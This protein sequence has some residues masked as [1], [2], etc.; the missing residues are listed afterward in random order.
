M[1]AL[2][3]AAAKE[4][5]ENAERSHHLNPESVVDKLLHCLDADLG[6]VSLQCWIDSGGE[7]EQCRSWFRTGTCLNKKCRLL[8]LDPLP[9][10]SNIRYSPQDGSSETARVKMDLCKLSRPQYRLIRILILDNTC[11]FDSSFPEV[12]TEY[13]ASPVSVFQMKTTRKLPSIQEST[14]PHYSEQKDDT[15]PHPTVNSSLYIQNGAFL[16]VYGFLS[17]KELL[18]LMTCSKGI[19]HDI[20]RHDQSRRRLKEAS[21]RI[22]SD[23]KKKKVEEKRKRTKNA[24]KKV[25]FFVLFMLSV[26][27]MQR[28]MTR[29][30]SSLEEEERDI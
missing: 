7:E 4:R 24:F 20:Q 30:T 21:D 10:A 9:P 5:K 15:H 11:V 1:A 13:C 19:K 25:I 18:Q 17:V 22:A 2:R 26:F 6:L 28:L 14:D 23:L 12:W 29:R 16:A 8:H 3:R 27:E